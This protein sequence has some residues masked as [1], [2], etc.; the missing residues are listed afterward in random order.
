M[1]RRYLALAFTAAILVGCNNTEPNC[2]ESQGPFVA[3]QREDGKY[4][5]KKKRIVAE[6]AGPYNFSV[7]AVYD[8]VEEGQAFE[9]KE[10]ALDACAAMNG[11]QD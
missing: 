1:K 8:P 2:G 9:A 3:D 6:R 7:R 11:L 10:E 4:V 5:L